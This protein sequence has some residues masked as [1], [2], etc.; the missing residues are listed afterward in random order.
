MRKETSSFSKKASKNTDN[1]IKPKDGVKYVTLDETL[2]SLCVFSIC[3]DFG[4]INPVKLKIV[5]FAKCP[6]RQ[7]LTPKRNNT[8]GTKAKTEISLDPKTQCQTWCLKQD[9]IVC[10]AIASRTE[11]SSNPCPFD[12][13]GLGGPRVSPTCIHP[14]SHSSVLELALINLAYMMTSTKAAAVGHQTDVCERTSCGLCV[15][16][17]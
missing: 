11:P 10:P 9:H 16:L 3:Q 14:R 7:G 2:C 1:Q 4:Q 12:T 6:S 8:L 17:H 15:L 13:M 5:V